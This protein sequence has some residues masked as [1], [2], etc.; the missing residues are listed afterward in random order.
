MMLDE[1]YDYQMKVVARLVMITGIL[2]FF[3]EI[4]IIYLL[5]QLI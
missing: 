1:E 5:I 4:L 3:G 2:L